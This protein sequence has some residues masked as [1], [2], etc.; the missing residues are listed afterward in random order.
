MSDIGRLIHDKRISLGM[1]LKQVG[2]SVS[3]GKSTVRKWETGQI[4]NMGLDK[5]AKLSRVLNI[6]HSD[7]IPSGW[8]EPES[9]NS[10]E[11]NL[12]ELYRGADKRARED[13]IR[14]LTDHQEKDTLSKAE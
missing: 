12:V 6:P 7:L 3:V 9:L 14:T 8:P 2:D 4:K 10:E 5:A 11:W 13:A 1:T